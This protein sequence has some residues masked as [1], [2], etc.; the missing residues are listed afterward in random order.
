MEEEGGK[1]DEDWG[2]EGEEKAGVGDEDAGEGE[3]SADE[4]GA[5]RPL[6]NVVGEPVEV[7]QH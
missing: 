3:E 7:A 5:Q 6:H 2:E 1:G 4:E